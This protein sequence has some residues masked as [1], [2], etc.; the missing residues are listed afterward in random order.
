MKLLDIYKFID[1]CNDVTILA[2]IIEEIRCCKDNILA[3]NSDTK[4][5]SKIESVSINGDCIQLNIETSK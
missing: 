2:N 3:W 1:D 4:L 5:L